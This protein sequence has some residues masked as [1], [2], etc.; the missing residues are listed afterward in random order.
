MITPEQNNQ[1][2]HEAVPPT[3][4]HQNTQPAEE[5]DPLSPVGVLPYYDAIP[6]PELSRKERE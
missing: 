4:Q 2:H 3:P 1:P 5:V 6:K